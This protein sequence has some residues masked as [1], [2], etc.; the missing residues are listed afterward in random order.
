MITAPTR[1]IWGGRGQYIPRVEQ[2]ALEAAI[3]GA[4]LLVHEGTGHAVHREQ[5]ARAAADIA[6]FVSPR[7]PLRPRL[8]AVR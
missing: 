8:A 4:E 5:P 2:L 1:L 6:A 3:P 7:G